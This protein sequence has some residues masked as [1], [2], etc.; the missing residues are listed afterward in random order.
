M[1]Y[2]APSADSTDRQSTQN[3]RDMS[4]QSTR[5]QRMSSID[6]FVA[7]KETTDADTYMTLDPEHFKK[8]LHLRGNPRIAAR[9]AALDRLWVEIAREYK[10]L[11]GHP[12]RD[13]MLWEDHVAFTRGLRDR[14]P[15]EDDPRAVEEYKKR[16]MKLMMLGVEIGEGVSGWENG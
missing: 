8:Y 2:Q 11:D 15:L 6:R 14:D 1:M 12:Q 3:T 7:P 4:T 5:D 10:I 16:A 13:H 9:D